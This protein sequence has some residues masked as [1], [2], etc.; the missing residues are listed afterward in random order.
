VAQ[1]R[2]SVGGAE[3]PHPGKRLPHVSKICVATYATTEEEHFSGRRRPYQEAKSEE[4]SLPLTKQQDGRVGAAMKGLLVRHRSEN[5]DISGKSIPSLKQKSVFSFEKAAD[6]NDFVAAGMQ[7]Q[8]R[9]VVPS[10]DN[11]DFQETERH[12]LKRVNFYNP[13]DNPS[14]TEASARAE[15]KRKKAKRD[16]VLHS[17]EVAGKKPYFI[18]VNK[19]GEPYGD[20]L[21]E[22]RA[23]LNK[24]CRSLDPSVRDVRQQPHKKIHILK[25]R[26]TDKFDY[27]GVISDKFLL[28]LIG[29]RVS[30]R[31][32]LLMN[33][34]R[35]G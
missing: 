8:E 32:N 20:G 11:D 22:W 26:L 18:M 19:Q 17:R 16:R 34:L 21:R 5:V 14:S 9:S 28:P 30:A 25:K 12:G 7:A 23:E 31:R 13:N 27:S 3:G 15:R 4:E 35:A 10:V 33:E 24:L 2:V 6:T 1:R 29:H